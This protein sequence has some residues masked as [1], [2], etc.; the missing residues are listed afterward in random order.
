MTRIGT[1]L[2][3]AGLALVAAAPA[4]ADVHV[5]RGEVVNEL[6][7]LGQDVRIDGRARGPV[8]VIGG[9]LTLGPTGQAA[10]V[11]VV[12]GRLET[13]PGAQLTGD[14]FQFGGSLPDLSG[15]RLLVALLAIL[16]LRTALVWLGVAVAVAL[17]RARE[18][19]GLVEVL[20]ERPGRTL[21]A[22]V[23]ATSGLL[24]G[25]VLLAISV[26]GAPAALMICGGLILAL[27]VGLGVALGAIDPA[28]P[29]RAV[30]LAL[31][32]P[33]IGDA[34]LAL[35]TALGVG[36]LLRRVARGGAQGRSV[37]PASY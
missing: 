25:G 14:V 3:V 32:I 23:L 17:A 35:A 20:R 4:A 12:A 13:A 19:G 26:V 28:P 8:V 9:N 37:S 34:L 2:L 5:A 24:A 33:L 18:F 36:A 27:L 21:T 6:R 10:N 7:V 29:R 15:W 11:T 22:G 16:G 31:A 30:F 1:L